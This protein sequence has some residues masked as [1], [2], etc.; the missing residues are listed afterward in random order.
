MSVLP[1]PSSSPS[2]APVLPAP[3]LLVEDDPLFQQRLCSV[4]LQL[5]Y[6]ADALICTATLAEAR[7]CLATQPIALALVDLQLPDGNGCDLITPLRAQD[8]GLAILVVT[9]WSAEDAILRALRAGATGYVL[10]ERDDFEV[11]L[12]IRSALRGGA[13]IDP[14]IARRILELLPSASSADE[15]PASTAP[16]ALPALPAGEALSE[17]ERGILQLVSLGQSNRE[18]A[19]KLCLSPYTVE[20]YIKRI[21]RKLEVSSRAMAVRTAL[22]RGDIT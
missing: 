5:G 11:M 12:S 6:T 13:P 2:S 20:S 9:A 21:Y 1:L 22:Q 15:T 10:K 18:I 4:L 7:A 14:F 8:P 3:V 17:R 19:H 16:Q